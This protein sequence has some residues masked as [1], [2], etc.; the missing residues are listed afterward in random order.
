MKDNCNQSINF[1]FSLS[2]VMLSHDNISALVRQTLTQ[3]DAVPNGEVLVSYLPLNHV[4][5]Q[6]LDLWMVL[7]AQGLTVFADEVYRPRT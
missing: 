2:G 6:I 3:M 5:A 7:F 4:M 1:L